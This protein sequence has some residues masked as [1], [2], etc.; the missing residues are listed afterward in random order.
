MLNWVLVNFDT[1]INVQSCDQNFLLSLKVSLWIVSTREYLLVK[2]VFHQTFFQ[3]S[4]MLLMHEYIV[5]VTGGFM[6]CLGPAR[7][8]HGKAVPWGATTQRYVARM[9]VKACVHVP[10]WFGPCTVLKALHTQLLFVALIVLR[11]VSFPWV[12]CDTATGVRRQWWCIDPWCDPRGYQLEENRVWKQKRKASVGVST[13]K[14]GL[15][16]RYKFL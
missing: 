10:P 11:N 15:V 8:V 6:F 7:V 13:T 2:V 16:T 12:V 9:T 5:T 14:Y 4:K 1:M 3:Y